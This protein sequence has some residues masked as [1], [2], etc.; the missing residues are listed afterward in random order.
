MP[1][2]MKHIFVCRKRTIIILVLLLIASIYLRL[3]NRPTMWDEDIARDYL[4]A[5]HIYKYHEFPLV[6]HYSS[7]INFFY[8]PYYYYALGLLMYISSDYFFILFVFSLINALSTLTMFFISKLWCNEKVGLLSATF[9]ALSSSMIYMGSNTWTAHVVVPFFLLSLLSF[10]IYLKSSRHLF[11]ILSIFILL[12]NSF[13]H[14]ATFPYIFLFLALSVTLNKLTVKAAAFLGMAVLYLFLLALVPLAVHF[15]IK[16]TLTAYS[17]SQNVQITI[18]II[19]NF[20][21][22][23]KTVLEVG[24]NFSSKEI[25]KSIIIIVSL[26]AYISIE[27]IRTLKHLWYPLVMLLILPVLSAIKS[28]NTY[29]QFFTTSVP[30]LYLLYGYLIFI[31]FSASK[32]KV[33]RTSIF[34]VALALVF[35]SSK[36]MLSLR[37]YTKN[38]IEAKTIATGIISDINS[39]NINVLAYHRGDFIW[40]Y[41]AVFYFLEKIKTMKL[42]SVI[43]DGNI[44]SAVFP[45]QTIYLICTPEQ[46]ENSG[47]FSCTDKF[48]KSYLDH[49]FVEISQSYPTF[50][51]FKYRKN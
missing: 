16:E 3:Q 33:I 23:T 13:I 1:N 46:T 12:F 18:D 43:N 36:G 40:D 2:F 26:T 28:G 20:F 50:T 24:Y 14:L 35:F 30:M 15:G 19:K 42:L 47:V 29:L 45:S 34:L 49:S 10:T 38:Y 51:V 4:T 5:F 9:Y 7:G 41:P 21:V 6:G 31:A 25:V 17:P 8:P 32:S 27:R 11:L 22:N 37:Y 44:L 48:E 39:L